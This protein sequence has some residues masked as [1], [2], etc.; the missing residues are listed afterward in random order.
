MQVNSKYT[1]SMHSSAKSLETREF[2]KHGSYRKQERAYTATPTCRL[3]HL[4][5]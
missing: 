3:Q 2:E 4:N 1:Y 5:Y